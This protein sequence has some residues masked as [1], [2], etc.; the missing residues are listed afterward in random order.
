MADDF[1]QVEMTPEGFPTGY[2]SDPV[3]TAQII[4]ESDTPVFSDTPAY[5]DKSEIPKQAF[6]WD[7]ARKVLGDLLPGR[8]QGRV[9]S[10][11]GF[12]TTS[13]VEHSI[14]VALAI[15]QAQASDFKHLC[16]EVTY[17]GSRVEV[18]GGRSPFR[19]DGSV[20]AWAAKFVTK[21]GVVPRANY[22]QGLNLLSYSEAV[23]RQMGSSGLPDW[24]EGVARERPVEKYTLVSSFDEACVALANGYA[25][26]VCSNQGFTMGRDKDGFCLPRG[27]WNHCMGL[28]GYTLTGRAGGFLLNSWGEKA[29][30][31]PIGL[32]NPSPAGF[33]SDAEVVDRMLRQKD[34]FAFASAAGFVPQKPDFIDWR[35]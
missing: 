13:A 5:R 22:T 31:G 23:C 35:K 26:A 28:V 32:G 33:W 4:L 24:L 12:G 15:A 14:L 21:W 20:G 19:G 17:G 25:V 7:A 30:T 6:L 34:S 11:V 29:H 2:I 27:V 10:C 1:D 8:N 18:N 16:Q 3:A 9:G